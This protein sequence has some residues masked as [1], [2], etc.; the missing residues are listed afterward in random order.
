MAKMKLLL[1]RSKAGFLVKSFA[2][3]IASDEVDLI[4]VDPNINA[5]NA[6]VDGADGII[7]YAGFGIEEQKDVIVYIKDK[8]IEES[9]L[10]FLIEGD[11]GIEDTLSLLTSQSVTHIFRRPVDIKEAALVIRDYVEQDGRKSKKTILVLDDSGAMLRNLKSWLGSKY[12]VVPANSDI[13]AIKYISRKI[14]DLVL[15]DYEMPIVDGKQVLEMIRTETEFADI[16]VIFLT[17]KGDKETVMGTMALHPQG[18]MLKSLSPSEIVKNV[19]DF[20]ERNENEKKQK[21]I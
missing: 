10:L 6:V 14:P 5:I 21:K 20:F 3:Y 17:S 16:P 1:V 13:M 11:Y 12:V 2:K 7:V 9:L 4:E 15:L 18:Y 19:D 8:V